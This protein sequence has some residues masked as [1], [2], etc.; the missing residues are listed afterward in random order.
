M[1]VPL[2]T[3]TIPLL[4]ALLSLPHPDGYP[5]L[6]LTPERQ[7]Q[8]TQET[9]LGWLVAEAE[10]TAVYSAWEDLHWADPSTLELLSLFLEQVPT[11]RMLTLLTFRPEFTPPWGSRAYLSQLTLSRLDR[12]QV[13]EMVARVTGGTRLSTEMVQQVITKTDGVPLFVEELTKSVVESLGAPGRA[14]LYALAIPATL[15]DALMARLDRLS[16]VRDVAQLGAAIG[17]EF[18]Y[19]LI[20]AV[21]PLDEP[22][23]QQALAK[24]VE[25][26]L[27]YQRGLPPQVRYVFKHALVQDTAYQSLLKSTRQHYHNQIA[28]VLERQFPDTVNTQPELVAHHYTEAG[29]GEQAIPYWQRAGERAMQLPAYAEAVRFYQLAL[30]VLEHQE[31]VDEAQRCPLLLALGEAQRRAGEHLEAQE[32]FLRAADNA[33]VLGATESLVHAALGLGKLT[34][35]VG[36]SA[37]PAVRLLEEALQA[38]GTRDSLLA[39]KALGYLA[40]AL[41]VTGDAATSA[42][43]RSASISHGPTPC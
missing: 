23:L 33:R 34:E 14:P 27:L 10:Q 6:S 22:S 26:E 18:S 19:E 4:A 17:R 28:Q 3:E 32:T 8:K 11:T 29:L 25:A 5:P 41:R 24:L 43:L 15:Q 35:Q 30:Q 12:T 21:S 37:A 7:K 16:T 31:A 2:Q 40:R 38:L 39:A 20:R 1:P 42:S 13:G 9:L 36:L